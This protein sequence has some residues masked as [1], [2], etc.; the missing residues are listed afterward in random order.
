MRYHYYLQIHCQQEDINKVSEILSFSSNDKYG[1][2][3]CWRYHLG[4]KESDTSI[5]FVNESMDFVNIFLDILEGKY[6][7]LISIGVERSDIS[8][9]MYYEY[10]EQCNMEF[11][12]QDMKRL[13]D[14]G[15]VLCVSCWQSSDRSS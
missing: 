9:W 10:D 12:P 4:Q 15:I 14:N 3:S 6:E 1:S 5:R 7:S 11:L 2:Y 13:G 8:V